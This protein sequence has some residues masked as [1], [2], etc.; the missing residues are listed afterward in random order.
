MIWENDLLKELSET[1][2]EEGF[3]EEVLN[4]RSSIAK[5]AARTPLRRLHLLRSMFKLAGG[6]CI[7]DLKKV[8]SDVSQ[9]TLEND[10]AFLNRHGL[11]RSKPNK[12]L[13]VK[14]GHRYE[15]GR[16]TGRPSNTYWL[17]NPHD[18]ITCDLT[19]QEERRELILSERKLVALPQFR[20][21]FERELD[22]AINLV[23]MGPQLIDAFRPFRKIPE[24]KPF[25]NDLHIDNLQIDYAPLDAVVV[26]ELIDQV[27]SRFSIPVDSFMPFEAAFRRANGL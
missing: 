13:T 7:N 12:R 2:N 16:R 14:W 5:I 15:I 8:V 22:A 6:V 18:L 20:Q 19:G 4:E 11:L 1:M 25:F 26:G 24:F 21:R 10:L 17:V 9:R 3:F 27:L 23:R